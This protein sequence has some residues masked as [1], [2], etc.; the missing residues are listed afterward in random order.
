VNYAVRDGSN[1]E[2]KTT[3]G[4]TGEFIITSLEL[5]AQAGDDSKYSVSLENSGSVTKVGNGLGTKDASSTSDKTGGT[6][7]SDNSNN[8]SDPTL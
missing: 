2:G 1:R 6:T 3:G 5:D 8:L 4:Y 7:S